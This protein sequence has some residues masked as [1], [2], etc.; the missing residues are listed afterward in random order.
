MPTYRIVTFGCKLNQA[1]GTLIEGRLRQLGLRRLEEA[2]RSAA[3]D[4]VILNS[5][6][7]TS[8]A[9]AAARQAAR[10]LRRENPHGLLIATGC[11]AQRDP[12]A[13][14]G[15]GGADHVVGLR[16][17]GTG[18]TAIVAERFGLEIDPGR[19]ELGPFGATDAC[20]PPPLA[21][22]RTRAFLKIQDGCDLRCSYCI[23]PAVRGASV[24]LPPGELLRRIDL[25][26]EAGLRE[27]VLTGVNSGDYGRDLDPPLPLA[28]LLDLALE[29]PGLGRLRLNSLEPRT[30]T[31]ELVDRLA[32]G[33]P[34][35][36]RHLQ[37]PL[38]SGSDPIL[39]RMRRPYRIA[40]YARVVETLDRRIPGIG[41]GAD[42]IVGF[43]GETNE[44]FEATFRYV[45]SSPLRY[46]HVFSYSPRPG[47]A[48]LSLPDAVPAQTVK[49]RSG[50]LRALGE[51]LALR[52]RR[53]LLGRAV[54]VLTLREIRGGGRLRALSDNFIDLD[55]DLGGLNAAD[56]VNRLVMARV[57]AVTPTGTLAVL[58]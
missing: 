10:R 33:A 43:P 20:D 54:P 55:L 51:E 5:C 4:L 52:F 35:L 7:V 25:L 50:R 21:A 3:A 11:Y 1:D 8:G 18:L 17:Q 13:L 57:T 39:K 58:A 6:T 40:D 2:D 30:V 24:S 31:P 36:A 14:R 27:I 29:R 48:A 53:S 23:I 22:E 47:T 26:I 37:I 16:D 9:D 46:L 56:W 45:A 28:R 34:R 19:R 41:L 38:Q 49:E 44:E 42:L 32:A 12:E 15:P